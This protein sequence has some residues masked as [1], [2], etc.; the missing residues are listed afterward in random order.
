MPTMTVSLPGEFVGSN[1]FIRINGILC[2]SLAVE[3]QDFNVVRWIKLPAAL[4]VIYAADPDCEQPPFP[5][6]LTTLDGVR[7]ER[8]TAAWRM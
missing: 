2:C 7:A 1:V 3:R 5:G 8:R 6:F 4:N